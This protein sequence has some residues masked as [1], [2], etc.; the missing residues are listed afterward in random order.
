MRVIFGMLLFLFFS[1]ETTAQYSLQKQWETARELRTPE[2]VLLQPGEKVL[3]VSNINGRP[4]EKDSNGFISRVSLDGEILQL[5][6]ADGLNAPK[7]SCIFGDRFYVTDI[8]HLAEIDLQTGK[9]LNRYPAPGA[10]FLNDAAVDAAGNVYISDSSKKNSVIYKFGKGQVTVWLKG[11]Q[12]SQPN[13]L[14]MQKER[15]IFGNSGDGTIKAVSLTDKKI[16]PVAKVSCGIDGLK[17]TAEGNFIISDWAGK[18][19]LVTA[20]GK[21]L[22]LLNTTEAKINAADLEYVADKQLL[23]IP[24][25]FDNRLMAYKLEKK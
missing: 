18:T 6:W 1:C 17:E 8:D 13:G 7:G 15:L 9:I 10:L 14:L 25:F 20:K 24:T 4:T 3:Y 19:L 5:K 11:E 21:I 12:V 22:Q 16:T 2:S 23:I